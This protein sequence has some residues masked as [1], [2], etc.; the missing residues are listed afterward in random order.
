MP[1]RLGAELSEQV[2]QLQLPLHSGR[3]HLDE[4]DPR[5]AY[6]DRVLTDEGVTQEQ[7]KLKGLRAMFFSKGERAAWC[8]PDELDA[9]SAQDDEHPRFQKM[10]L[11]F[12]LPRGSYATLVVKRV[13]RVEEEE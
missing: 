6:F 5:K 9:R 11:R 8:F 10:T 3:I 2:R 13:T 4:S 12:V 1:R 7:F